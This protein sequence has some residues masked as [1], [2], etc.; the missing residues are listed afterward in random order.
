MEEQQTEEAGGWGSAV[1]ERQK[2]SARRAAAPLRGTNGREY[3]IE[4]ARG[5]EVR[6]QQACACIALGVQ[7][8]CV[9]VFSQCFSQTQHQDAFQAESAV[10][11]RS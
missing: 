8:G 3:M 11:Q 5:E 9:P 10:T 2:P 1:V 4:E 6:M 7:R